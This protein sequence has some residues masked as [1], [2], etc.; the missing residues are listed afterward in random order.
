MVKSATNDQVSGEEEEGVLVMQRAK[1]K[2]KIKLKCKRKRWIC[3]LSRPGQEA[4]GVRPRRYG[5]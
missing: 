5:G 3:T 2:P 4:Q 1:P